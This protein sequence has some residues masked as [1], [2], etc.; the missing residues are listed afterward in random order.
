MGKLHTLRRAIRRNPK[1]FVS[2]VPAFE[3]EGRTEPRF[4]GMQL[5]CS[6]A[7]FRDGQWQAV[8]VSD[9]MSLFP[10]RRFVRATLRE[11]GYEIS[12]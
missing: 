12:S 9:Q 10:Y 3:Q 5:V 7:Q 6:G 1:A 4:T 2:E 11:L 8:V